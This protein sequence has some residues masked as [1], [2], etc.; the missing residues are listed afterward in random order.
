MRIPL[1]AFALLFVFS[2]CKKHNGNPSLTGD[3]ICAQYTIGF[4]GRTVEL[5]RDSTLQLYLGADGLFAQYW[6]NSLS[7]TGSYV[8]QNVSPLAG[9]G[10]FKVPALVFS[11]FYRTPQTSLV[12]LVSW[13]HDT[14][15]LTTNGVDG[16]VYWY[17]RENSISF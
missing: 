16:N 9:G 12:L 11:T 1:L 3:W 13:A 14:L 15:V 6:Q 4:Q 17:V 5:P 8:Y 10:S 2:A 7:D